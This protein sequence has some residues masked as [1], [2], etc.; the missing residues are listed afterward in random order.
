MPPDIWKHRASV[1]RLF[2]VFA[3]A[4]SSGAA[5][6]SI[7]AFVRSSGWLGTAE[8]GGSGTRGSPVA[9]VD[10]K[11]AA[12][13]AYALGDTLHLAVTATDSSGGV[14]VGIP[15]AW[16][17]SNTDVATVGKGGTAVARG[18]GTAVILVTVGD[19]TA[20]ARVV[21]RQ[22][23]AQVRIAS[24]AAP[25]AEGERRQLRAQP[26]DARGQD[27]TGRTA[28]WH[29][30]DTTVVRVDSLGVAT[31]IAPGRATVTAT[32]DSLGDT[33]TLEVVAV[34]ASVAFVGGSGQ[35]APAGAT[36]PQ[37]I[38]V[39]VTSSR[40]Q[41]VPGAMVRLATGDAT[42]SVEPATL[43]T[44]ADGRAMARWTLGDMPGRQALVA[45][46]E[47]VATAPELVAEA[48]PVAG[49]VRAVTIG[50]GQSAAAGQALPGPVGVRLTDTL[51]RLLVDVPVSWSTHDG[52]SL[53]AT[54]ARTDSAGEARALWT[55]GPRGGRQRA[56]A[57]VGTR[58]H[59]P[60]TQVAAIALSGPPASFVIAG[61]D[62][63]RGTVG[64][65]L[66]KSVVVRVL[67][68][69]RNPV[70]GATVRVTP[71]VGSVEDSALTTDSLGVASVRWTL[72]PGAGA[73]R[74]SFTVSGVKNRA[75]VDAHARPGAAANVSLD[76]GRPTKPSSRVR[77]AAATV[78]DAYGNPVSGVLVRFATSAGSAAPST[79]ATDERGRATTKWTPSTK[80]G[81]Q[82][83]TATASKGELR[84]T[85]TL[86]VPAPTASRTASRKP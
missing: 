45:S 86:E 80:P 7:L 9:W 42:G 56:L 47:G 3:T 29:S 72:G 34:P 43:K 82:T 11:P 38:V 64:S 78:T 39:R 37:P 35:V 83:L 79:V 36:L 21:V 68:A 1:G 28:V 31:G 63:Q 10:L 32:V 53:S 61:G 41:P 65:P 2:K 70:A 16:S 27:V 60:P 8:L 6:V 54:A 50:D 52:G 57:Y 59:L 14:L 71:A 30:S 13:T 55:L 67:D 76:L 23:P 77:P 84:A 24:E 49:A 81:S 74:M 40:G 51:G 15:V 44:D 48:E 18:D 4:A 20:R 12:D 66:A 17:S 69:A 26:I 75:T 46:T 85:A 58:R 73:Q 19:H 62:D 33:M 25:L 22:R 5:L